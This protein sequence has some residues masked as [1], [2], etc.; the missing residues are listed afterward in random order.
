MENNNEKEIVENSAQEDSNKK[1]Q[2][3]SE[4]NKADTIEKEKTAQNECGYQYEK[5]VIIDHNKRG[6]GL[7]FGFLLGLI[8]LLIGFCIYPEGT[9]ER[10]TFM[11][12]WVT[13]FCASLI[14]GMFLGILLYF[15]VFGALL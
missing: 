10:R 6:I 3:W 8:G 1:Y 13:A 4:I 12:G 5:N 11:N 15:T 9:T 2:K 14:I 7:L